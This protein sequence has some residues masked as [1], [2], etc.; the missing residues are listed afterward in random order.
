MNIDDLPDYPAIEQIRDAL[1]RIGETQGAAVMVGAGFSRN[2]E[3]AAANS[4]KPPVWADYYDV[5]EKRLY[6]G[7]GAPQDP[8]KL[9]EEYKAAFGE[10]ALEGLIFDL[11]RDTEWLPGLLHHKLLSLPWEDVLT[12]NWDT[13]LERAAAV[14]IRQTYDI[15]RAVADIPR[16]KAPRIVKLH[17]S[18]PSSRP[19]IFTEEDYRTYP[20]VFAPFVNLVQQ[21][22]LENELCLIGFSGN[23]PN[24]LQWSGWVR[25]ELGAAARRI[26]LVGVLHLSSTRRKYLEARNVSP[27]DL[28]PLVDDVEECDKPRIALQR[29]IDFLINSKPRPAHDWPV[30]ISRTHSGQAAKSMQETRDPVAGAQ[31]LKELTRLWEEERKSYPGWLVCPS[32]KRQIVRYDTDLGFAFQAALDHIADPERGSVIYEISWRFDIAFWPLPPWLRD[33]FARTVGDGKALGL[34]RQQRCHLG[35]ILLRTAREEREHS[36]FERWSAFLETEAD[37]DEDVLAA[38]RY[39]QCLWARDHLDYPKLTSLV[40]RVCGQDPAWYLRRAA[41]HCELGEYETAANVVREALRDIRGRRTRDR[42]SLWVLSRLAWATFLARAISLGT[43]PSADADD[44]FTEEDEWRPATFR[45]AQCDP[46]DEL[47]NLDRELDEAFRKKAKDAITKAP[48]FDAGTYVDRTATTRFVSWAVVSPAYEMARLA[49]FVALP[50]VADHVDIM[51]TRLVR[52]SELSDANNEGVLLTCIRVLRSHTD[53]IVEK[54]F[55]R[56]NVAR[57]PLDTVERLIARLWLTIDFGSQRFKYKSKDNQDRFDTFWVE[58]VRIYTEVLSRLIV[59]LPDSKATEAFRRA[60]AFARDPRW[61][62]WW[63]FGPLGH[64]LERSLTAVSPRNRKNLLFD[65]LDFPLPDERRIKGNEHDWPELIES[66]DSGSIVRPSDNA[67]F[68]Q[69]VTTLIEKVRFTP[70]LSRGRAALR[71]TYLCE[72]GA[73]NPSEMKQFGEALWV[74]RGDEGA[75]PSDTRLLPYVFLYLPAPNPELPK[76]VFREQILSRLIKEGITEDRLTALIGAVRSRPDG[77]RVFELTPDEASS[78]LDAV[79]AWQPKEADFDLGEIRLTNHAIKRAIG[80][81]LADVVLPLLDETYAGTQQIDK[82]FKLIEDGIAPSAISALPEVSRLDPSR[83]AQIVRLIRRGLLSSDGDTAF[84]AFNAIYRWRKG[85]RDGVLQTCPVELTQDV[86]AIA[87]TRREPGL[88][89]SLYL[90]SELVTDGGL[91]ADDLARLADA[92]DTLRAETAYEY[93]LIEDPRTTTVTLVRAR[94]V[95][96]AA[97]LMAA[98]VVHPALTAWVDD[99]GNDPIPEVRHALEETE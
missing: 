60:V 94:C 89:H 47:Y 36:S 13:L 84:S 42:K 90:V 75:F 38:A 80:P 23:D 63:L 8:L 2:A 11:V 93:W 73:L 96:L 86:V 99:A 16:T 51:S 28:A 48:R 7:G 61:D 57:M 12:T 53:D 46:W 74:H 72:A 29:F 6:P 58:R 17:G 33:I 92:L 41:L 98:G 35:S 88:L 87:A 59:R 14:N 34:D 40:E 32:D 82:L 10:P 18:M 20:V 5:M 21:V 55:G 43:P 44:P 49:D 68:E 30:R 85:S 15:T 95:R 45:E 54:R 62:H 31:R 25:D 78:V 97:K 1:W 71:L 19:F 24:F 83:L 91:S 76:R 9:A 37:G 50:G 65:V 22:L 79:L 4:K 77:S 52:A 64:L 27:I 56:I 67:A 3:L 70:V 66:L 26:H 39:E 81:V 69:R